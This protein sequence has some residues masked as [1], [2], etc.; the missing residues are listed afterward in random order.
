MK[1]FKDFLSLIMSGIAFV[2]SLL[3]FYLTV[4][5][6]A[7]P[8]IRAG[9]PI[10]LFHDVSMTAS[11]AMPVSVS[12]AGARLSTVER[13]A[14]V[15]KPDTSREGYM[16]APYTF[17]KFNK[18]GDLQDESMTSPIVIPGGSQTTKQVL[19][20]ASQ[21]PNDNF[22][23]VS[24]GRYV[25]SL[26]AWFP[27]RDSPRIVDRF[28]VDINQLQ[29][30]NLSRWRDLQVTNTVVVEQSRWKDWQ[31]GPIKDTEGFMKKVAP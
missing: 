30:D 7:D 28:E 19:F 17:Q 4:L 13:F 27:G 22:A 5:R 2:V 11:V 8:E 15:V 26:L 10:Y 9:S 14:L 24:Q 31:P 1:R 18:K 12:N 25:L 29:A 16:F 6:S 20:K 23:L 3:S 21:D